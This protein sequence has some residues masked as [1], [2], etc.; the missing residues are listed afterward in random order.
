MGNIKKQKKKY[1][2]PNIMWD[3]QRLEVERTLMKD[4]G[5]RNKKEMW[6][7]EAILRRERK[8]AIK[9]IPKEDN[10]TDK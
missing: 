4:Y 5:L 9:L 2:T 8:Q 1:G 6:R 3:A 7:M 10:Q